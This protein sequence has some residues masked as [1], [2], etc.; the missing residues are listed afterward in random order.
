MG[1]L[2]SLGTC[3]NDSL[4][5]PGQ[6]LTKIHAIVN[7]QPGANMVSEQSLRAFLV[8]NVAYFLGELAT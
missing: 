5:S 2:P 7:R 8:I 4:S 3:A 1:P 6:A